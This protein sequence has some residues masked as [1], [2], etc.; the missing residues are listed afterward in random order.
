MLAVGG[1]QGPVKPSQCGK[2]Y[3]HKSEQ[4]EAKRT[5]CGVREAA[6]GEENEVQ[7][8]IKDTAAEQQQRWTR[9]LHRSQ[10]TCKNK[11][12]CGNPSELNLV[13]CN[14]DQDVEDLPESKEG[15]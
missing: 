2:A 13:R 3:D 6:F 4:W 11:S 12:A 14:M 15:Q 5:G 7:T 9:R 8:E 10:G 1:F